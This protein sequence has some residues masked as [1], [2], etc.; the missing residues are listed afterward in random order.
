ME[1]TK[2]RA[3]QSNTR[4]SNSLRNLSLYLHRTRKI[5]LCKRD[6]DSLQRIV[7]KQSR[8][9]I[10]LTRTGINWLKIWKSLITPKPFPRT[11]LLERRLVSYLFEANPS[12]NLEL[13]SNQDVSPLHNNLLTNSEQVFEI[14]DEEI[15]EAN[16]VPTQ[17][18]EYI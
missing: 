14:G 2:K 17:G 6:K 1:T 4:I 18:T 9:K 10:F 15:S 5:P 8:R 16:I 11:N 3:S 12:S 7:K 13:E